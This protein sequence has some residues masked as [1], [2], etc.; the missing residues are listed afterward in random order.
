MSD[1]K[2]VDD[3]AH[4]HASDYAPVSA[5]PNAS[6][7]DVAGYKVNPFMPGPGAT[8]DNQH[9]LSG[10]PVLGNG[11]NFLADIKG[12]DS[13]SAV[14]DGAAAALDGFSVGFQAG[15]DI[16][17]GNIGGLVGNLI[18]AP[19][20]AWI[21]DHVKP[22]R[23]V[24]DELLGNPGTVA[25]VGTTWS[26]MSKE[27]AGVSKDLQ[28][29]SG[30][31]AKFWTGPAADAYRTDRAGKLAGALGTTAVL[32]E[33]WGMLLGVVSDCVQV[34]H[35]TVRDLISALVAL[36]VEIAVNCLAEGP[37][38]A[39]VELGIEGPSDV[40]RV[41]TIIMKLLTKVLEG[42]KE[43]TSIAADIL[44]AVTELAKVGKDL[45]DL[46]TQDGAPAT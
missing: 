17:T 16:A 19:L 28:Q 29:Q 10:I 43:A 1:N 22:L 3:G 45:W 37:E 42:L 30:A 2:L 12:N 15:T 39:L 9:W 32:C 38:A 14:F 35:D 27:L 25:A 34:V 11:E 24:M 23:L 40:I 21:L 18:A 41:S 6:G 44:T 26:N 5:D 13:F 8:E 33:A 46:G 36:L 4:F 20:T 31:T 7:V